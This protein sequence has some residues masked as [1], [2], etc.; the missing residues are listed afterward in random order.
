MSI[1]I[2]V[3]GKTTISLEGTA[4]SGDIRDALA[5][6]A[7]VEYT[8]QSDVPLEELVALKVK[9]DGDLYEVKNGINCEVTYSEN[10]I[11]FSPWHAG[12]YEVRLVLKAGVEGYTLRAL[13]SSLSVRKGDSLLSVAI[14]RTQYQPGDTMTWTVQVD[15]SMEA[16]V[17]LLYTS[18]CV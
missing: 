13:S 6:E 10:A 12:E 11:R 3:G 16:Y 18:R 2:Q 8:S 14:D 9:R 1:P 17:C 4:V 7:Y 15:R 5:G